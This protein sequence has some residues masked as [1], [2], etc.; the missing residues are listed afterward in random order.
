MAVQWIRFSTALERKYPA[1]A[2]SLAAVALMTG[3]TGSSGKR[4]P[5]SSPT[6]SSVPMLSP[7]A[8]VVPFSLPAADA[9]ALTSGFA[10]Q[11]PSTEAA[12]LAASVRSAFLA[13]PT[14][15]LPAGSHLTIDTRGAVRV[16]QVGRVHAS[17]TGPRPGTFDLVLTFENGHWLLLGTEQTS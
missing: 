17:V 5:T 12:V 6:A 16:G 9:A 14:P 3:C 4:V 11:N 7:T 8:S 15:L 13:K 10:S 2:F 1:V